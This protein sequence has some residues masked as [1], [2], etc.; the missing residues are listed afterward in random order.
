MGLVSVTFRQ[1]KPEE[2]IKLVSKAGLEG[3]EW[4]GDIHVP[5]GDVKRAKEVGRMTCEE[6]LKVAAYGSY[7]RAGCENKDIG[8]FERVLETAVEL[9]API[10]RVWAGNK[11]SAAADE[12]M[13][14][15]VVEDSRKIGDLAKE[16]GIKIVFE[17]HGGTLTDTDKSAR[18]L[19]GDVNSPNVR[20]YW[21][22][23]VDRTPEQRL[24]DLKNIMPYLEGI[25]VFH[26]EG[27]NR[28]PFAE[29]K[30]DWLKYLKQASQKKE[31][32]FALME[33]VKDNSP[34]QFLEDAEVFKETLS[35]I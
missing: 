7:Y 6:G 28:L 2:I 14:D 22:P 35:E 3:I 25:H 19:L 34:E 10:I 1:L 30:S 20:S 17:Y 27:N 12:R 9:N 18:K 11:G 26:W 8:S 33:F 21:Q 4:G 31:D 15:S 16:A 5:H 32:F 13:W 29:G 23:A 24:A